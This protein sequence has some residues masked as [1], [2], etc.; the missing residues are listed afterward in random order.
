MPKNGDRCPKGK[1]RYVSEVEAMQEAHRCDLK[2]RP[3]RFYYR[4]EY[5]GWW[6]LTSQDPETIGLVW[7]EKTGEVRKLARKT[8]RKTSRIGTQPIDIRGTNGQ[9]NGQIQR[10]SVGRDARGTSHGE[11]ETEGEVQGR[12]VHHEPASGQPQVRLLR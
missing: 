6:H 9:T 8:T 7:I 5:C 10:H 4:C 12:G 11:Q 1:R 2:G 3:E